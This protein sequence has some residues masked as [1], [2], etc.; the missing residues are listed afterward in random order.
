MFDI[1]T[2]KD[3]AES[4]DTQT[5]D[6]ETL[7]LLHKIMNLIFSVLSYFFYNTI[8]GNKIKIAVGIGRYRSR[9]NL[10]TTA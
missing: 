3:A 6:D 4:S 7:A 5:G 10:S 1:V 8:A 9:N 2:R